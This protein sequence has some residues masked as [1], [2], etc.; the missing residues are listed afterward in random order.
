M[1][2]E[3][4]YDATK[5]R[6][7]V[8]IADTYTSLLSPF[9]K[10][11]NELLL[12]VANIPII[13]YMIDFL[14]SNSIKEIIF[15]VKNNPQ[16]LKD[17]IRFHFK[18]TFNIRVI[19]SENFNGVG[20]CLREL[21]TENRISYDFVLIRGLFIANFNLEKVFDLHLKARE[22]KTKQY[23][24][25]CV[26][27]TFKNE[28]A[29]RTNY[30]DAVIIHDK[31]TNQIVQYESLKDTS[32][33]ALN[34]N[35]QFRS[36][37][38]IKSF[39]LRYDLYDTGID[40]CSPDVINHFSLNFDYNDIRDDL[41][42]NVL[43]SEIYLDQFL[44][45][46]LD[47][48]EYCGMIRNFPSYFKVS[49]EIIDRWAHPIV[50]D[51]I[52]VSSKMNIDYKYSRGFNVYVDGNPQIHQSANIKGKSVIGN[53]SQIGQNCFVYMTTIGNNTTINNNTSI[54]G[55]IILTDCTIGKNVIIENSFIDSNVV[56]G[57]GFVLKDCYIGRFVNLL[58]HDDRTNLTGIR[59][60]MEEEETTPYFM[61]NEDFLLNLEDRD[62]LFLPVKNEEDEDDEED[63]F[64]NSDIE[65][66]E[67][68]EENFEEEVEKIIENGIIKEHKIEDIIVE[69]I[70]LRKAFWEKTFSD[71]NFLKFNIF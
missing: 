41:F 24:M 21:F 67:E 23:I 12:P 44:L 16:T 25:T 17:Y 54:K 2:K 50:I 1:N 15:I 60:S 14:L 70:S 11:S 29:I 22:D 47:P 40:I 3:Q 20:D 56:I 10:T 68:E 71:S 61:N 48:N 66:E 65:D 33:F 49:Q 63:D 64:T 58:D 46:E 30:D 59:I 42:K 6:K 69:L 45:H 34:A 8:V 5:I 28:H 37:K 55:S 36:D 62:I 19:S 31:N 13:E 26:M 53:N 57:D 7:A 52:N 51:N 4:E 18:K 9:S 43:V 39:N 27:K 35:L 38:P 32:D